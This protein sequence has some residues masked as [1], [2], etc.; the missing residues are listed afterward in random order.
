MSL[1]DKVAEMLARAFGGLILRE[2][3]GIRKALEIGVD[4]DREIHGFQPLFAKPGE[5]LEDGAGGGAGSG[6]DG[7]DPEADPSDTSVHPDYMILEILEL[8]AQEN[9]V[10]HD[11]DTDLIALGKDRGWLNK[12]GEIVMLPRGYGE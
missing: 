8:L 10:P 12:E 4:S 2:L 1:G 9:H 6:A 11:S 7:M 3:K 5:D